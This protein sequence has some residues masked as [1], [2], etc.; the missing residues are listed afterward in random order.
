MTPCEWLIANKNKLKYLDD[1][2]M[3][4]GECYYDSCSSQTE[5]ECWCN[6][7]R[8]VPGDRLEMVNDDE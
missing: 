3:L 6:L 4:F 7:L 1:I 8:L 2:N 5:I